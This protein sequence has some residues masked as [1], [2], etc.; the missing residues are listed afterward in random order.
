MPVDALQLIGNW[1][2]LTDSACSRVYPKYIE[3]R[4]AGLYSGT[5]AEPGDVPGWD[6][7]T[8]EIAG[9]GKITVSTINDTLIAYDFS[10]SDDILTFEDGNKCRFQYRRVR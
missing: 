7:G 8:W 4:E 2:K 5:G 3:F 6:A 1:E 10:V 9:P